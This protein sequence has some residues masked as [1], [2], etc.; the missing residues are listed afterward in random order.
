MSLTAPIPLGVTAD[1]LAPADLRSADFDWTGFT[2]SFID[3][4]DHPRFDAGYEALWNEFGLK[5]EMEQRSVI[6]QRM[7]WTPERP[8]GHHAMLYEMVVVMQDDQLAAV[9]DHT[10]IVDL[11]NP[12]E[13]VS[14]HLSHLLILPRFRGN[15]LAGWMR[16]LPIRAARECL[17]RSRQNFGSSRPRPITLVA[18]MEPADPTIPDRVRRLSAYEKVGFVKVDPSAVHYLQ[19]DFR[20]PADIDAAGGPSPVPL[21]LIVRRVK[22]E[23][24]PS[25]P[26]GEVRTIVESLYAMYAQ[27]FRESDMAPNW[28]S[29]D[30]YPRGDAPIALVPPTRA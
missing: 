3:S 2:V 5:N 11:S 16:A 1:D 15:G 29:L 27:S 22:R 14:V 7:S 21:S 25:L 4:V 30:G 26:A 9:R 20:A 28:A 8:L 10:A 19:P 23:D 6:A 12:G 13:P 24:E 17:D 18:E